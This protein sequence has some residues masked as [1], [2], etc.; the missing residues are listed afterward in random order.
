MLH[1]FAPVS[2]VIG[3]IEDQ[4]PV[5]FTAREGKKKDVDKSFRHEEKKP[6]PVD[7]V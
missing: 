2:G 6:P 5:P 1:V 4:N 3:V 7:P